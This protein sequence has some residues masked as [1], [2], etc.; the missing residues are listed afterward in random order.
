M[1]IDIFRFIVLF[2]FI[3]WVFLCQWNMI[4]FINNHLDPK[5]NKQ[6]NLKKKGKTIFRCM[7]IKEFFIR[8]TIYK[9][10]YTESRLFKKSYILGIVNFILCSLEVIFATVYLVLCIVAYEGVFDNISFYTVIFI[11]GMAVILYVVFYEIVKRQWDKRNNKE[12]M[13]FRS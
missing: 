1:L 12:G 7:N 4:Y 11:M 8:P 3:I 10:P 6:I 13:N 5:K 9:T 2:V